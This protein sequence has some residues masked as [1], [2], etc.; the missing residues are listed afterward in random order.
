M[1]LPAC[2]IFNSRGR[3]Y[4]L[5]II[6][7]DWIKGLLTREEALRNLSE[8]IDD[9]KVLDHVPEVLETISN[10]AKEDD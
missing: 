3:K 4:N 1:E 2:S 9:P 5:C 6:C 10:G 7:R 8:M